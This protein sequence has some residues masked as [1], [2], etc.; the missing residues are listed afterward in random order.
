ML[1]S[2]VLISIHPTHVAKIVD[3]RKKVE[4]RRSWAS[5]PVEILALYAT[6]PV[7]RIVALAEVKRVTCG[8]RDQLWVMARDNGGC[9]TQQMLFDYLEGKTS[10]IAIELEGVK[11]IDGGID[12][13]ELFGPGFRAPQ[14]YRYLSADEYS[15]IREVIG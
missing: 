12:P 4:F 3:G 11:S 6:A 7:R 14:S 8:S 1:T 2:A 9:L 15:K 5:R 13:K 10:G